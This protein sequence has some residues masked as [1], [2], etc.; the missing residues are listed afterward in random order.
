ME[1]PDCWHMLLSIGAPDVEDQPLQAAFEDVFVCFVQV[2]A[3]GCDVES[4]CQLRF[5]SSRARNKSV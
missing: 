2:G 3:R 4:L 5:H 1:R